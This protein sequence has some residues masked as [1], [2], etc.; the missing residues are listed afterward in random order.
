MRSL[1]V[2]L[3]GVVVDVR[4]DPEYLGEVQVGMGL[5]ADV[6]LVYEQKDGAD[7]VGG[8]VLHL[9]VDYGAEE[10]VDAAGPSAEFRVVRRQLPELN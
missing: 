7:Y 6:R 8:D 2:L 1:L 5:A 3:V 9:R 10:D 4:E